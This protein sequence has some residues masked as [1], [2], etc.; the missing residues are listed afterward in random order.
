MNKEHLL[1]SKIKD[2]TVIDHIPAGKALTVLKILGIKGDE[3]F[4]VAIVMNVASEKLQK[5]D[6]VKIEGRELKGE[7]VNKIALIAPTATIN[8]IRDYK[9]ALKVKVEL[10]E[11]IEDII[12]CP[13]PH[14][15]TNRSREPIK[16][17]FKLISK[18]PVALKCMYCGR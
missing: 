7:E 17:K 5:K 13:N 15:I 16:A 4:R 2:G 1:V 10:P 9:V 8:I 14:C 3:G 12:R 11:V 18:Q 6:I